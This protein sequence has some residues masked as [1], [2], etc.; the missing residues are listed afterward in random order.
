MKNKIIF[1]TLVALL[2]IPV[3]IS[4]TEDLSALQNEPSNIEDVVV[5]D[6]ELV[7]KLDENETSLNSAE[8]TTVI[9]HKE[10]ISKRKLVKKF[11]IAM[12]A[13]GLSSF[14][15]YFGLTIYNKFKTSP[16]QKV[17]TPDGEASLTTP[18]DMESAFKIFLEKTK[19]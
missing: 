1:I 15:L 16:A 18:K 2:S 4:A 3:Q 12:F 6:G 7:Q 9:P 13:V 10:P 5:T 8:E 11:L 14:A 19:W 17:K